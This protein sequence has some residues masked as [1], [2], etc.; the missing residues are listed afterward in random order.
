MITKNIF[1]ASSSELKVERLELIDL[2]EDMER[3][4]IRYKSVVW[5][6]MDK[7][8]RKER[9]EDEYLKRLCCCEVCFTLFWTTLGKYTVEELE[10][11][12]KEQ[13]ACRLPKQNY[14]LVKNSSKR[15]PELENYI[16]ELRVKHSNIIYSFSTISELRNLVK[17]LL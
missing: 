7:A 6:F 5:E 4:E 13:E 1:I 14:I 8:M 9:K 2:L 16:N 17:N 15:E 10:L 11:A 3:N 12:L